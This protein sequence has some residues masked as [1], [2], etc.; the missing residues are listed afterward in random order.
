LN[1]SINYNDFFILIE[2]THIFYMIIFL[3]LQFS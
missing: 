3:E 1:I 2:L